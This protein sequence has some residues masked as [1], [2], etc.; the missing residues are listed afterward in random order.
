MR[1]M[2]ISR[3]RLH[4]GMAGGVPA[5]F[6]LYDTHYTERFLGQPRGD[7]DEY[8]EDSSL[9]MVANLKGELLLIHGLPDDNVALGNFTMLVNALQQQGTLFETAIYPGQGHGFRGDKTWSHLWRT[10][11]KFLN[12][13]F[14]CPVAEQIQ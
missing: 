7:G 9:G 2:T 3:A 4:A 14:K 6:R 5:D 12:R 10:Y 11:L 8:Q 1:L 13:V